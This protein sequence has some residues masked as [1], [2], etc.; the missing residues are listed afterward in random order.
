MLKLDMTQRVSSM[1]INL[2]KAENESISQGK[3]S[4]KKPVSGGQNSYLLAD[5]EST[6]QLREHLT[7]KKEIETLQSMLLASREAIRRLKQEKKELL[8]T[9]FVR[10]PDRRI[11]RLKS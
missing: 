9:N 3:K 2:S 1:M 10:R 8:K 6:S 7:Q 5:I 11:Y 4:S